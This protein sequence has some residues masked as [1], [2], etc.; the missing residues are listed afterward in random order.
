MTIHSLKLKGFT[1]L[2][3]LV[4]VTILTVTIVGPLAVMVHSSVYSRQ[5]NDMVVA[6]YLA[7]E[8]AEL[9]QNEYDSLYILCKKNS[10]SPT[11]T[12]STNEDPGQI[13]WR[14]FKERMLPVS[15]PSCNRT[16]DPNGCTFDMSGM[17]N[18]D[19]TQNPSFYAGLSTS[20]LYLIDA[21]SSISGVHEGMSHIDENS[22]Q[23]S[24]RIV[25]R[26]TCSSPPPVPPKGSKLYIRTVVI[27]QMPTFE[28]SPSIFNQ[29][30]DDLRITST[31]VSKWLTNNPTTTV[32]RYMHARQ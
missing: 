18:N 14:V 29:Y 30:N 1:L 19:I 22:S 4:S 2:E 12:T 15:T 23:P 5:A 9:L 27:D 25:Y 31:I 24:S 13:A 20:C 10:T 21:T 26:Y 28:S 32:V 11:C 6:S 3:T 7:E 16:V 17:T 8:G